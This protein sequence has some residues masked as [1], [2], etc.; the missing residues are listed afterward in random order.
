MPLISAV[1]WTFT[2]ILQELKKLMLGSALKTFPAEWLRQGLTFSNYKQLKYGI[3]QKKV[4][5]Y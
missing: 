3:V 4:K 2:F 5:L 1:H